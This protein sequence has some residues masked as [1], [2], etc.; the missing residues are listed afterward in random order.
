MIE[1]IFMGFLF[2]LL[3]A[4]N[5]FWANLL[6]KLTNRIMSRNYAEL[7]QAEAKPTLVKPNSQDEDYDPVAERQAKELNSMLGIV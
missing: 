6:L 5:V 1:M 3:I 4:S 2:S 7:R